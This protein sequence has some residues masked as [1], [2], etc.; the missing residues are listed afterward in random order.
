MKTSVKRLGRADIR[1]ELKAL[2]E[3]H[4]MSTSSFRTRFRDGSLSDDR[5]WVRWLGLCSMLE[6][7]DSNP[8]PN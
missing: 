1:R 5:D 6:A 4:G 8:A 3:K 2:E 7:N